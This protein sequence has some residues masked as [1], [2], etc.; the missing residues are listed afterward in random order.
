MKKVG[1][2]VCLLFAATA[3]WGQAVPSQNANVKLGSN[4]GTRGGSDVKIQYNVDG[5]GNNQSWEGFVQFDLSV[6]PAN[7]TRAMIQKASMVIYV[8]NGGNPGTVTVC[9]VSQAWSSATITGNTAPSCSNIPSVAFNVSAT[10]LQNGSFITV[11]ITPIVQSWYNGTGNFGIMLAADP[12]ASG[13]GNG[14]NVSFTSLQNSNGYPPVLNLV[15]QSQGPMG[16]PG[17]PGAT[18]PAGPTG[19]QGPAGATGPVGPA[20]IQG[21][22][23]VAGPQGPAGPTGVQGPSGPTG[24]QGPAGTGGTPDL[25]AY[26][27]ALLLPFSTQTFAVGTLPVAIA[28][29]GTNIWVANKGSQSVT[30]LLATTGAVENT[31]PMGGPA[32]GIAFDGANMW[33]SVGGGGSSVNAVVEVQANTGTVIGTFPVGAGPH[34]LAFDGSN[35]WVAITSNNTVVELQA[36]TG[37]VVGTYTLGPQ[38]TGPL[39]VA[40][41]GSNIWVSC[42]SSDLVELAAATGAVEN[43]IYGQTVAGMGELF[44]GGGVAFDGTNIWVVDVYGIGA[45]T[46][47]QASNATVDAYNNQVSGLTLSKSIKGNP[48]GIA[49]D[50]TFIWVA[51]QSNNTVSKLSL[52]PCSASPPAGTCNFPS[53]IYYPSVQATY[54]VGNSPAGL[55]FDGADI[56]VANE[57]SNTVT[58]IRVY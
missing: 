3:T 51:G 42:S 30:E 11:D 18:G 34:G 38:A 33:V 23:G 43:D 20:G 9:Q 40:F 4:G 19:P 22:M 52:V 53:L 49:F 6:F 7:L 16:P 24:P 54:N 37:N 8:E 41:D 28:F 36:S 25:R 1:F 50:G 12:P 39:Y 58:K 48:A 27:A 35:I 56:W 55:A 29:D 2:V 44:G 21:P 26:N 14:I 57:G 15:L 32:N 10:Q 5:Q 31:I 45:V 47:L 13:T 17:A 46:A